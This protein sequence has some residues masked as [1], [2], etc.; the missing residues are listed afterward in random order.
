[1]ATKGKLNR[2]RFLA[3]GAGAPMGLGAARTLAQTGSLS[4]PRAQR[5]VRLGGTDLEVSDISFGSSRSSDPRLV[6]HAFDRGVNFFDSAE[7]Y[8]SGRAEEAIGEALKDVRQQVVLT[9]KTKAWWSE[10]RDSMMR[11]LEASLTRLKTDYV[12]IY[13]N[14]AVNNVER[15]HNPEWQEFTDR[16]KQQGKIRYRGISG[17]GS[18]LAECLDYALDQDLADV[19]LVA[20]NFAQD[21]DFYARLRHTFHYTSLQPDLP[22]LLDKARQKRVGVVAM[23]TLYGARL[24][25]MRA[26]EHEGGT[27]SQAAFRWVLASGKAD[28]LVVSMTSTELIDEYL[29][30]SGDPQASASD[31]HMLELYAHLQ[32][33]R[34]CQH[35]CNACEGSCPHGVEIAEVLRT[36]MYDV[37]YRDRALALTDYARLGQAATPCL[38]C[39]HQS[40]YDA[41]PNKIPIAAFTRDAAVRLG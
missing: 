41:C 16:A 23:K 24:N 36:R 30:A 32:S 3:L 14:H 28:A 26:Y 1:M 11:A 6:R 8:R 19:V 21:P 18:R 20:H 5:Y 13:Y 39:A 37:D 35:G 34:Y 7:S 15:L 4:E 33:A 31:L 25:D 10:T 2:R 22:P 17:H 38:S 29:V 9:S 12:D 40:C 27:F